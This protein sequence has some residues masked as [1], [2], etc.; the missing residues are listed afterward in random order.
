MNYH[1]VSL[2]LAKALIHS[3]LVEAD[4]IA[5]QRQSSPRPPR[6]TITISREAGALGNSVATEVGRRLDW[7]VYDRNILDKI[8]EKLRR[9]PSHLEDVDERRAT[10]LGECLSSL[11]DKYHVGSN[12]Y[13]MHLFGVVRSLGT[14]G[15]C[16]IV[17]RGANFLLP[18][19]TTLRVR[20]VARPEDRARVIASRLGLSPGD[21]IAWVE[22]TERE[23]ID[24]IKHAFKKDPTDAHDY[25]MVLNMSFLS[26][27]EAA[28]II[29]ETLRRRERRG[30]PAERPASPAL[31]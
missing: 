26:V 15:S 1:D 16:V 29:T 31:A 9:S 4:Q 23:R 30:T 8:G 27:D 10:W 13:L 20:L 17:G 22:K 12:A 19:E 3:D 28:Q 21:A 11:F 7:L 14:T 6:L 25:D 5:S 2:S 24:F 18:A